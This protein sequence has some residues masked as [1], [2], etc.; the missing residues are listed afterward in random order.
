M[1]SLVILLLCIGSLSL[2]SQAQFHSIGSSKPLPDSV[3]PNIIMAVEDEIYDYKQEESFTNIGSTGAIAVP[4]QVSLFIEKS[5]SDRNVG[6]ILYKDMPHGEILRRFI[7]RDDGLVVLFGDPEI[8]F[9]AQQPD[10]KT[11]YLP[12]EDICSFIS[13]ALKTTFTVDP[14]VS[15][16]RIAEAEHRQMLRVRYSYR[17]DHGQKRK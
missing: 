12:E 16:Q 11:V 15:K 4:T 8:G 5:V 10:T 9:P 1:K 2:C 17:L 7:I 14:N 3:V 6:W 13:S